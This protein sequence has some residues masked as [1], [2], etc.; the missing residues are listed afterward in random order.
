VLPLSVQCD[1]LLDKC[2][3][4]RNCQD[5]R[6]FD[7]NPDN[8]FDICEQMKPWPKTQ[9]RV[10][11]YAESIGR[12]IKITVVCYDIADFRLLFMLFYAEK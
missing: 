8:F 10:D 7:D 6:L 3:V 5:C 11:F 12:K 2:R 1:A 9:N 4:F